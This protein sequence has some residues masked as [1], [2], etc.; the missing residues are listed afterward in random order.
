MKG[1]IRGLFISS[2]LTSWPSMQLLLHSITP[3]Q[4]RFNIN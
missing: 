3:T 1:I 4:Q 2:L